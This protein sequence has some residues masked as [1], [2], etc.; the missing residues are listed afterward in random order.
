M[1]LNGKNLLRNAQTKLEPEE[2]IASKNFTN[3]GKNISSKKPSE[4]TSDGVKTVDFEFTTT[5]HNSQHTLAPCSNLQLLCLS[6]KNPGSFL[7]FHIPQKPLFSYSQSLIHAPLSSISLSPS[8]H[9]SFSSF[10]PPLDPFS[11]SLTALSHPLSNLFDLSNHPSKPPLLQL[12][13]TS[14]PITLVPESC[15]EMEITFRPESLDAVL[16]SL[17]YECLVEKVS[18]YAVILIV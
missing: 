12:A 9:T 7:S 8:S 13:H 14:P 17:C 15:E 2:N 16:M 11:S 10:Q 1:L 4:T 5:F 18:F 6:F 3:V